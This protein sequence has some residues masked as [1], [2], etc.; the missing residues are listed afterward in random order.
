MTPHPYGSKPWRGEDKHKW[1]LIGQ[2]AVPALSKPLSLVC[3]TAVCQEVSYAL[4]AQS[5]DLPVA[6]YPLFPCEHLGVRL[7]KSPPFALSP[8]PS[9]SGRSFFSAFEHCSSPQLQPAQKL[10]AWFTCLVPC[11]SLLL[12]LEGADHSG[13][14]PCL[15]SS[16]SVRQHAELFRSWLHALLWIWEEVNS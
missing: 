4:V 2:G 14:L 7:R 1:S 12:H 11:S 6:S 8:L 13:A 5:S 16:L 9:T 3:H 10:P 15:H